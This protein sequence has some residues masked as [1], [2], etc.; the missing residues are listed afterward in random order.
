VAVTLDTTGLLPAGTYFLGFQF[1]GGSVLGDNLVSLTNF[2]YGGGSA[3]GTP[4]IFGGASGTLDA[5]VTITN[6]DNPNIF[7]EQFV[8]GTLLQF[9]LD[10]TTNYSG[11]IPHQFV[12]S[13]LDDTFTPIP[14]TSGD[15]LDS[16]LT[17]VI[18][19][20]NPVIL[21]YGAVGL[22]FSAPVVTELSGEVPEPSTWLLTSVGLAGLL[23]R[24]R[25]A[26]LWTS[27][28]V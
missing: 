5:G 4:L 20:P 10:F 26:R 9:Q 7:V 1:G 22:E 11:G 25:F 28:D 24:R 2:T 13:I 15:G 16:L 8:P 3:S 19:S 17:F 12:W 27:R 21:T 18:D 14:T 23:G 6:S